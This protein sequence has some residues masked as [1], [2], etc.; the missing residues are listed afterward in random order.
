[1]D[2][3]VEQLGAGLR[4]RRAKPAEIRKAVQTVL[5]ERKYRENAQKVRE[6]FYACGGAPQGADFIEHVIENQR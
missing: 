5:D 4:L 2:T 6:G 1:V 3:R